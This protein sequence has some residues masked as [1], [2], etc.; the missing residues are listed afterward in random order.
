MTTKKKLVT[1][2]KIVLIV[3]KSDQ[4]IRKLLRAQNAPKPKE[5]GTRAMAM[6]HKS[7]HLYDEDECVEYLKTVIKTTK[8]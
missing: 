8:V 5:L 4:Y 7:A 6:V 3:G 2:R 1:A